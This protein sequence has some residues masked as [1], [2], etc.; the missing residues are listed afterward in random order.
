MVGLSTMPALQR[1][2]ADLPLGKTAC[3]FV[4][5]RCRGGLNIV[6]PFGEQNY[7]RM[8][9]SIAIRA[10]PRRWLRC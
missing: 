8:R 7:Y 6:V 9:P 10:A 5:T 4:S 2:I 3:C 1:A